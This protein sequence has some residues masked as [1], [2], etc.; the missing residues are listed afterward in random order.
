MDPGRPCGPVHPQKIAP[1]RCDKRWL[2]IAAIRD[3]RELSLVALTVR[4]RPELVECPAD[5]PSD[6]D[7]LP[8]GIT[9]ARRPLFDAVSASIPP[10]PPRIAFVGTFDPR[11]GMCEF[12]ELVARVSD[13]IPEVRFRL[14][15]TAGMVP[16]AGG[17]AFIPISTIQ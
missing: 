15:G 5:L 6:V 12:P 17:T 10:G 13:R 11:K 1:R 16:D 8:L 4:T 3:E 9:A 7:V 14:V 2:R